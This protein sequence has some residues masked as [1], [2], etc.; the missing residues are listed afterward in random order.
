M[1][2]IFPLPMKNSKQLVQLDRGGLQHQDGQQRFLQNIHFQKNDYNFFFWVIKSAQSRVHD[3]GFDMS[4]LFFFPKF[5]QTQ[6]NGLAKV[7]KL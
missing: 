5:T 2:F 7:K 3:R 1:P 6:V 4:L